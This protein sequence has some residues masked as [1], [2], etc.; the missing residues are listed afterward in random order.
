MKP[1]WKAA[2]CAEGGGYLEPFVLLEPPA[3]NTGCCVIGLTY[4]SATFVSFF[5]F[6]AGCKAPWTP[7]A[8]PPWNPWN[9]QLSQGTG[10]GVSMTFNAASRLR[11]LEDRSAALGSSRCELPG[12]HSVPKSAVLPYASGVGGLSRRLL[13]R[14]TPYV[15]AA[16]HS[17]S[18][19]MG[20]T[21]VPPTPLHRTS[22][23]PRA[24]SGTLSFRR[25]VFAGNPHHRRGFPV[26][27]AAPPKSIMSTVLPNTPIPRSKERMLGCWGGT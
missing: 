11:S 13:N 17:P 12:M 5:V 4:S 8:P 23:S 25:R 3:H 10:Q 7:F 26:P 6:T 14:A 18:S 2:A 9:I 20:Q 21:A 22:V 27:Q 24:L 19:A 15:A 1:P 16:G